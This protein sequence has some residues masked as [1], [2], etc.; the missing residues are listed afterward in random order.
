MNLQQHIRK[1]LKEESDKKDRG[2]LNVIK[3][4]GLYQ[5]LEDTGISYAEVFSKVGDPP[6]EVKIQYLKDLIEDREQTP[7]E[8]DLTFYTGALPLW[9]DN[10]SN[11]QGYVEFL[12]NKDNTLRVHV[13]IWNMDDD[14]IAEDY[15]IIDEEYIDD[16][17][18][19]LIVNE[20]T[21]SIYYSKRH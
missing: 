16:D 10:F 5:F 13:S 11:L 19:E 20:L 6:R 1:V 7:N 14:E 18:L 15:Q 8:L 21:Q 12:S 9:T 17:I 4:V 3:N 2:L